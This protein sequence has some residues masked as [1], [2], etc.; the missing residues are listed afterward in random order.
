MKVVNP[1]LSTEATGS[2]GG[3]TYGKNNGLRIVRRRPGRAKKSSST[4]D[5]RRALFG[6]L[7]RLWTKQTAS[8]QRDWN[9]FARGQFRQNVLGQ[10]YP[11]TGM[12]QFIATN[13][14]RFVAGIATTAKT[15]PPASL[16]GAGVRSIVLSSTVTPHEIK[17]VWS[18]NTTGTTAYRWVY[19]LSRGYYS[20]N[21][22]VSKD[23]WGP[24]R[25]AAAATTGASITDATSGL[26]YWV[27]V[28]LVTTDGQHTAWIMGQIQQA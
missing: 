7:T 4:L 17:I 5:S 14:A 22:Q 11:T 28:S 21:H 23:E 25:S 27:R 18:V 13:M 3:M 8:V 26:W 9:A 19:Q 1:L 2:V 12:Q 16:I 6:F 24:M 20:R 10:E 15:T